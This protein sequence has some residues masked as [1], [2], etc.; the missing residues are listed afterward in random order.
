MIYGNWDESEIK[1]LEELLTEKEKEFI[2]KIAPE[3][4]AM[5][6]KQKLYP[7]YHFTSPHGCL[8]DP[9]G[10]CFRQGY[11]H[12]FYQVNFGEGVRPRTRNT[13]SLP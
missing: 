6:R 4:S 1:I 5:E 11:Y 8:N 13:V 9:N 12:L 7:A 2:N 10:L 3:W